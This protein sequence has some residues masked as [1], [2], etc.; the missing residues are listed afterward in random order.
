MLTSQ[1]DV[2]IVGA[3][4]AGLA[5]AIGLA[6]SDFRVLV[7]EASHFPGA[8]N[9]SGCVY[10]AENLADPDL[11]GP[12]GVEALA[13]ERRLVE[14][15]FFATDGH[16]MLGV[17]Y[18][19]PPAFRHCYTVLRPIFDHHLAQVAQQL[20]AVILPSTTA[21]SLIR[22]GERVVGVCTNRGA[23]YADLVFLAEGDASHLVTREGYETFTDP[24]EKPKF[25]QGIKQVIDL[26]PGAIESMFHVGPEEGVAY[27]MLLRNGTLR[28]KPVHLNMGGFVYANRQSLSVGL[29]LPADNLHEHFGGDP[30]LLLEWFENLPSL[31]PWF[32]AGKRGVYGA[33]I[34]RGG[35]VRDI[36]HLIDD[37]LAI[38]GAASAIGVDFPYPNFT[39]P[40]TA[41]GLL[42]TRAAR[43]IRSEGGDFNKDNLERHY[44]QPL[45]QS[46]YYRDVEYLRRWPEYVKKTTFFFDNH[47]DLAL[48]SANLWTSPNRPLWEKWKQWLALV[49]QLAPAG[50]QKE[51][52]HLDQALRL[53]ESLGE[54][55]PI[56]L[57]FQGLGNT[58]RDLF[59]SPRS[60]LQAA[61]DLQLH[62]TVAG[63]TDSTAPLPRWIQ[64]RFERYRPVLAAAAHLMYSNND[65]PLSRKIPTIL[66]LLSRQVNLFDVLIA[67]GFA[68]PAHWWAR[69]QGLPEPELHNEYAKQAARTT[70]LTPTLAPAAQSWERRLGGL[71][72]DT[73][74]GSHIH[75]NWPQS[76]P[77]RNKVSGAGLWHVCPAHVYEARTNANGQLQVVVN[78]ENCIKC[79]TCWRVSDLVDWGRDG[80]H[81]FVYPV[82]SP[83]MTRLL[84]AVGKTGH[85]ALPAPLTVDPWHDPDLATLPSRNGTVPDE[86]QS[87]VDRLE[88]KLDEFESALA[89]EPRTID[90]ARQEALLSLA[91]HARQLA[92]AIAESAGDKLAHDMVKLADRRCDRV[93]QRRYTWAAAD[94]RQ[95]RD[96]HLVGLRAYFDLSPRSTEKEESLDSHWR[97]QLDDLLGANIWRELEHRGK[98]TDE[99]SAGLLKLADEAPRRELLADLAARDPS[100]AYRMAH[101]FWAR[102]F[103]KLMPGETPRFDGWACVAQRDHNGMSVLV[104]AQHASH[105]VL[106]VADRLAIVPASELATA[107][108][109]LETLGFRGAGLM[110]LRWSDTIESRCTV[111]CNPQH[112]N[113]CW[114]RNTSADLVSM[115]RGMAEI[116]CQRAIAHATSRVQFPGMFHDEQSRDPIG[117]FGAIKRMIAEM[118]VRRELLR[119]FE[120][121]LQT[122]QLH[123]E[124]ASALKAV[125]AELLAPAPGSI[126][127][128]AGQVFGGTGFSEDDI[129][130]KFFRDAN[131][132]RVLGVD[133]STVFRYPHLV[134]PSLTSVQST[135]I[136]QRNALRAELAIVQDMHAKLSACQAAVST[137]SELREVVVRQWC[138]Y[139]VSLMFLWE[140]HQRSENADDSETMRALLRVWLAAAS[141]NLDQA[142][143]R[144]RR[145]TLPA[146]TTANTCTIYAN[147]LTSPQPYDSGD[148]LT[149]PL[150][151]ATPRL[152]PEMVQSDPALA[153]ADTEFFQAIQ[154]F[155][156]RDGKNYERWIESHH[157]PSAEDLDYC[158][159]QG[160]FRLPIPR[161]LG[162]A[163]R[164]KLEYYLLVINTQRFVDV[165]ISLLIQVNSSLGTTPILVAREKDLPKAQKE[166]S[167]FAADAALH[168]EVGLSL[169]RLLSLFDGKPDVKAIK[170]S[171][172]TLQKRLAET[173]LSK[174][175]VRTLAHAFLNSWQQAGRAGLDRNLVTMR[176]QLTAARE[177]WREA[178][179]N[180]GDYERELER[181]KQACDLAM[182]WIASGQI[183]GFALTEP[184]AGSDT[185]RIATR[186][187]LCSVPVE[188][189]PDGVLRFVPSDGKE[190]RYLLDAG[191]LVFQPDGV[192]YRYSDN[193]EPARLHYE[194][195]DY[196]TD[197]PR[198]TPYYLH[199][200][201]RVPFTDVSQLRQRD[202]KLWYDYWEMT[203]AKMWI[204]NGRMAGILALYA[205]TEEGVTAFVVD[206]HAEGLVV[207]KDEAKM[208]QRGSPTNELSLQSVRVP[209]E[210]VLGLEGRGQVNALETLNVGR[211]G[212]AMSAMSQMSGIQAV[213]EQFTASLPDAERV[214]AAWRVER[215]AEE[216]FISEAVAF[217]IIGC[218]EHPQTK[219]VRLESAIA[220]MFVSEALHRVIELAE[221][222]MGLPGQ[223]HDYLIEKRRRDARV[224][225]IYEGTNEIQ[226]FFI[227]R[228]VVSE[229]APRWAKAPPSPATTDLQRLQQAVR[230]RVD[231]A[232]SFLGASIWQNP[233]FQANCFLLAEAVAWLK[234]AD[235]AMGRHVWRRSNVSD[236]TLSALGERAIARCFEEVTRRLSQFDVELTTLKQGQYAP[237]VRAAEILFTNAAEAKDRQEWQSQ[238]AQPLSI[239]VIASTVPGVVPQPR[240]ADGQLLEPFWSLSPASASA[241]EIALRLR[242][243][244]ESKVQITVAAVGSPQESQALRETASLGVDAIHFV[245]SAS[246]LT[247]DRAVVELA[248]GV[249][250]QSFDLILWG[251]GTTDEEGLSGR[252]TAPTLR[253]PYAGRASK[254]VID[255][256]TAWLSDAGGGSK[257]P[258]SLPC[259]VA[260]EADVAL[261]SF[262]LDDFLRGL[263]IAPTIHTVSDAPTTMTFASS[264]ASTSTAE[265]PPHALSVPDAADFLR[266]LMNLQSSTASTTYDGPIRQGELNTSDAEV[267]A[268]VAASGHRLTADS[269]LRLTQSLVFGARTDKLVALVLTSTDE[270]EQRAVVAQVRA[271]FTGHVVLVPCREPLNGDLLSGFLVDVFRELKLAP[272]AVIGESWAEGAFAELSRSRSQDALVLRVHHVDVSEAGWMLE[273]RRFAG[274]VAV[275]QSIFDPF[276]QRIWLT[277]TDKVVVTG[278]DAQPASATSEVVRLPLNHAGF[279][280]RDDIRR[281]IDEVKQAVGVV[282]LADADFIL[283]VGFGVVNRDGYEAVIDPLEKALRQAGVANLVIGGSRKVTE[284]LH[285]LPVD[286]QIGQSGVSVNP[287][288][289]LAVGISGAPQH[290]NYI[291]NDATILA[292]NRDPEAPLMTLNRRQSRP[293]VFPVLGDLFETIPAFIAALQSDGN[294]PVTPR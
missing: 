174:T 97:K 162:G 241:L 161:E 180:A 260:V 197:D 117:K 156:E 84:T 283:D 165:G 17:T 254:L 5:A 172:E 149:R 201:R 126:T 77:D 151:S 200:S 60:G 250:G 234:A 10:F 21:E 78:F 122:P 244:A 45:L 89:E 218:F 81:R 191:R 50:L 111:R 198:R 116:L 145:F 74:K 290:L 256:G 171:Y 155:G 178:C 118:T 153:R 289:L 237:H 119:M 220:K 37:G 51:G 242:D 127:Y 115:A 83:V 55:S 224:L 186:A 251:T 265:T 52:E 134:V 170:S 32:G 125:A 221:E 208:G 15:G 27:E 43:R 137:S 253:V 23:V 58:L 281:L 196:E 292:F 3:G 49:D 262:T 229:V 194:E 62:Y 277:V 16:G 33:K 235:S 101:H 213:C 100:L 169:D 76:L 68:L 294:G 73:V 11:L 82:T 182:R 93:K 216:R 160:F 233:N 240:V 12:D 48:G 132:W 9:W 38:G 192:F 246:A 158:R 4:A 217:D 214:S 65:T 139:L 215:I 87:L 225:N 222:V 135:A 267:V 152:V 188:T 128:N 24:Q 35:G 54:P 147:Y 39:G 141:F 243:H 163:K 130:S 96:H 238:I 99:Q 19:D 248:R 41:M 190:S 61:G 86:L 157:A 293:R 20:G 210:N 258:R 275:Q 110:R 98:L 34:I 92:A 121:Q 268:V 166:A 263:V 124:Y 219:S 230:Q 228:D 236:N 103:V 193:A 199:G 252:L 154:Y 69:R 270:G 57:F 8:E 164:L 284:E 247:L 123:L 106:W 18:R 274:K 203:G 56:A 288:V 140:A 94:G 168:Q 120:E 273:T 279:Y 80:H 278:V 95:M 114:V 206:R 175:A 239:L 287:R 185:A 112:V 266:G 173:V 53:K 72:Y 211:A 291:G 105:I 104:P 269:V 204:T 85:A 29:V 261:R 187:K 177:R 226:R 148:F 184:S 129:L 142:I 205:R 207:G 6:R 131:A 30:N 159:K 209:R 109:P 276:N 66:R 245:E 90:A 63:K 264:S 79:E 67:C 2:V 227:L 47:V 259:A 25:L 176:E 257:R 272:R 280:Q 223:T 70:D 136:E 59:G 108:E 167:T 255:R 64:R 231:N 22:D 36:P 88:G 46:H 1:F 146:P 179:A 285:L 202:G 249:A 144:I 138:Y 7:L 71:G 75:L 183:S 286:R 181:R 31:Q 91:Q 14:R 107:L 232:L 28:G 113:E 212:L 13:W 44:L 189:E 133:N 271:V 42:L 143:D 102:A 282:R 195:Y 150:D 40:A 26:P